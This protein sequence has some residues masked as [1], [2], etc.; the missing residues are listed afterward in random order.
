MEGRSAMTKKLIVA[1]AC[2]AG[3]VSEAH[4]ETWRTRIV[5]VPEKSQQTCMS[6]DLSKSSYDLTIDGTKFSGKATSGATFSTPIGPSGEVKT[7]FTGASG[8]LELTGD[9]TRK[10]IQVVNTKASCTFKLVPMYE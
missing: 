6:A 3:L 1:F 9:V 2:V 10:E 4:A 5:L 8:P 7:I